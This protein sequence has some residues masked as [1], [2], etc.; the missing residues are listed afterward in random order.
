[1]KK[2]ARPYG[3]GCP[4]DILLM[5]WSRSD[6]I[7]LAKQS[8]THCHGYGLRTLE[9]GK[10]SPCNCVF[11]AIFRACYARFRE[12]VVKEKY[13]SRVSLEFFRGG[14]DKRCTFT[15]VTEDYMADFCLVAKRALS[16]PD[17]QVFRFH[18]LLGAGWR[19][20]C[21]QLGMERGAFFHALYRIEQVLGR[22]FREL[23]PYGLY[24]IDEYFAGRVNEPQ[25]AK[26]TV[27]P[28]RR[29]G[30]LRAPVRKSA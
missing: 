3:G 10:E 8:C 18:F 7:G 16:E 17:Y 27:M 1:M 23:E 30:R 24:P 12:C 14:R 6:T 29:A 9:S 22:T 25:P 13:M 4:E 26:V 2:A 21:R 15:R 11:R 5:R 20:C 28:V 19:L